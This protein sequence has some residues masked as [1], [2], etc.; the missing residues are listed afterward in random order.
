LNDRFLRCLLAAAAADARFLPRAAVFV[1][2]V[3]D[4]HM[5]F[6]IRVPKVPGE[7]LARTWSACR[8]LPD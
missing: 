2:G 3:P 5:V 1:T 4:D 6:D 7:R 8:S